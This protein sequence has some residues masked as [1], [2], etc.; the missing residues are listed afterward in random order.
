[1]LVHQMVFAPTERYRKRG[2]HIVVMGVPQTRRMIDFQG[3]SHL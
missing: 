1:M 3:K 2:L